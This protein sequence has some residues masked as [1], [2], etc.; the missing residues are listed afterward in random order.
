MTPACRC[1]PVLLHA[2]PTKDVGNLDKIRAVVLK[3]K[4]FST[5][6]LNKLKADVST[7]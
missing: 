6:D 4:V 5:A 3:G 1:W 7:A 2:N